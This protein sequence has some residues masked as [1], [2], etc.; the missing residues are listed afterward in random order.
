MAPII[1][2]L[3]N[4]ST[5]KLMS[6]IF[7]VM[8]MLIPL[9]MVE[10][11]IYERTSMRQQ[12]EDNIAQSWG[13]DQ[14]ITG[15]VLK[16]PYKK[17]R[18]EKKILS[19]GEEKE[20]I[21]Y[22]IHSIFLLSDQLAIK[23]QMET[24]IRYLGIYDVPVYLSHS[25]I[26]A[27]FKFEDLKRINK[28]YSNVLWQ[29]AALIIP[30]SDVRGIRELSANATINGKKR[31]LNFTSYNKGGAFNG[32]VADFPI[33]PA[34]VSSRLAVSL[35]AENIAVDY[36]LA[37]AGS[38]SIMFR[39]FGRKTD[40]KM[41]SDWSSP[42]F[43]GRFLPSKRVISE[44]GFSASWHILELN[45]K[46]PQLWIDQTVN[47]YTLEQ[48]TFGVKLYQ[49]V[50]L[51]Q[52]NKR[53]IKYAVLFIALTFMTFFLFEILY[54]HRLHPMHYFFTGGAL[55]MFYLLLLAFSEHTGFGIAYLIA[56]IS[57]S[58]LMGGYSISL[59]KSRKRGYLVGGMSF[60][61]YG[62]FY[63]LIQSE[64][65]A[66]LLG[67]IVF[68][69]VLSIIMYSTRNINWSLSEEQGTAAGMQR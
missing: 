62:F 60:V 2:F 3:K 21:H 5:F 8:I 50:N 38:H 34:Y 33:P 18:V 27:G 11:L 32:V 14:I 42:S 36:K 49:P 54:K 10:D 58:T 16:I 44:S 9:N 29:Q 63:M 39:P 20:I 31:L 53:S 51:Y 43:N 1:Q 46:F 25:N 30:F 23:T 56:T 37:L 22:E 55:S 15:P 48:A 6:I 67:S 24:E 64:E 35:K 61:L 65:N 57:V 69:S 13:A 52:Q 4:N 12:A 40:V 28:R 47:K 17:T 45:R 7:L 41:T 26:Q 66:L 68:F 19:N 59:F